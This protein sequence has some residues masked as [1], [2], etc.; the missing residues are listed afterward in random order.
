MVLNRMVSESLKL[1]AYL[2]LI[3][4]V[5]CGVYLGISLQSYQSLIV[6]A[7]WHAPSLLLGNTPDLFWANAIPWKIS[8][9]SR[10]FC[11]KSVKATEKSLLCNHFLICLVRNEHLNENCHIK[12]PVSNLL[13]LTC[14]QNCLALA[15]TFWQHCAAQNDPDVSV[16]TL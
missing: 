2:I 16:L 5:F 13:G 15:W 12:V 10:K 7:T 1:E 6:N 9:K 11:H 3:Q 4:V 8:I 14:T